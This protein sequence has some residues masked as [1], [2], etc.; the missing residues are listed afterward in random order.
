ML[1]R[2][3]Y[4]IIASYLGTV[5]TLKSLDRVSRDSNGLVTPEQ[6]RCL[7]RII[8][9][10][11]NCRYLEACKLGTEDMVI[12]YACS[13][14]P[15]NSSFYTHG[16]MECLRLGKVRIIEA[17]VRH[18]I[19]HKDNT[20]ILLKTACS[21]GYM[22]LITQ[23]IAIGTPMNVADLIYRAT[24]Y[25]HIS[26]ITYLWNY[27]DDESKG[28]L[29][30]T[31]AI[32]RGIESKAEDSVM[33][34]WEHGIQCSVDQCFINAAWSN[35]IKLVK[36][37][38]S[39]GTL[40]ETVMDEAFRGACYN[41][42]T[43]MAKYLIE[44]GA[45]SFSLSNFSMVLAFRSQSPEMIEYMESLGH[46]LGTYVKE[47]NLPLLDPEFRE[48]LVARGLYKRWYPSQKLCL[49]CSIVT[50]IASFICFIVVLSLMVIIIPLLQ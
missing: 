3:L 50:L 26:V 7:K 28:L 1:Y 6:I 42:N 31:R 13:F 5:E 10:P 17:L 35:S 48:Y 29:I 27:I 49:Y 23:F 15:E 34:L 38:H 41:G 2:D 14:T 22:K 40:S 4:R 24:V 47:S 32:K 19:L 9:K 46:N 33:F 43:A 45:S 16:A 18:G 37:F 8:K 20:D 25:N 36:W 21:K 11:V 39:L 44:H 12:H 30:E